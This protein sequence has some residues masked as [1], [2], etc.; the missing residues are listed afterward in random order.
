MYLKRRLLISV[1]VEQYA[2]LY[3]KYI[4]QAYAEELD[5]WMERILG[6][7]RTD[8]SLRQSSSSLSILDFAVIARDTSNPRWCVCMHVIIIRSSIYYFLIRAKAIV[9]DN[10]CT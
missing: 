1:S 9:A 6:F 3:D 5:L 10:L 4:S 2:Y 7:D 8:L